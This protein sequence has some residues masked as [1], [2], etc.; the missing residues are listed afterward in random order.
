M[1]TRALDENLMRRA[2]G[3]LD[4]EI[5]AAT[6]MIIG[7]GAALVL[8]YEHP[9]AT[10]YVDAFT[11][12]GSLSIAE[13]DA[14]AKR[15]AATLNAARDWLNDHFYTYTHVLP[16]DYSSRLR[17]VFEGR[18]LRVE[19]LGPEDLLVMKCFAGRAKDRAHAR[20]LLRLADLDFVD[21]HL[22]DLADRGI[23]RSE[24]AA[25][26]FDDLRDAE[27]L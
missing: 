1:R 16:D 13:M 19:A 26:Y 8:A 15:V 6:R 24:A 18:H 25:D 2:L 12:R 9:L 11:A 23:H 21:S 17:P 10:Q 27:G 22:S 5:D 7:G 20:V 3:Q 14:A 4:D